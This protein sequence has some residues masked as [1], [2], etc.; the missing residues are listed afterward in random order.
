MSPSKRVEDAGA[1]ELGLEL[2]LLR[3]DGDLREEARSELR[4]LLGEW[5]GVAPEGLEF[6]RE[7][8]P[9]CGEL[10]GRPAVRRGG[11]HF[12]VA[13]RPGVALIGIAAEPVG[14]D[15]EVVAADGTVGDVQALLH[16]AERDELRDSAPSERPHL[17]ARIWTRKE[18]YLKGIGS[19]VADDL[20][21]DYLGLAGRED[22][23]PG[24][25]V[26]K[27]PAPEGFA[28]AAAIKRLG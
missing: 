12:S 23:P 19:G 17:F 11:V 13:R 26:I 28:A 3:G 4:R 9:L 7:P 27:V 25:T 18:A 14:V 8:C 24:W 6:V 10:H 21:R 22:G 16:P 15:V 20:A 2:W 1:R 5:L